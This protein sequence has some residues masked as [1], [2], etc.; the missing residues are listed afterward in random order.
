MV[1]KKNKG[2]DRWKGFG[3]YHRVTQSP[4]TILKLGKKKKRK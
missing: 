4:Q 1:R 2:S 3:E